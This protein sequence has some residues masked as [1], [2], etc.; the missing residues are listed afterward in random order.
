MFVLANPL[1]LF[2]LSE[3]FGKISLIRFSVILAL[4]RY[5]FF[6]LRIAESEIAA[7]IFYSSLLCFENPVHPSVLNVTFYF[8]STASEHAETPL[9]VVE[10]LLHLQWNLTLVWGGSGES[11]IRFRGSRVPSVS[12]R[13]E[14]QCW[15]ASWALDRTVCK[16]V[17][18][19]VITLNVLWK[20]L[21]LKSRM[22]ES[23]FHLHKTFIGKRL[24][25][26]NVRCLCS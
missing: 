20:Q 16:I 2:L 24:R 21:S 18:I 17:L 4:F 3:T 13:A 6:P 9:T 22:S 14:E 12:G 25:L 23:N 11:V 26:P 15:N 7:S 19:L 5:F 8:P 1:L 10:N